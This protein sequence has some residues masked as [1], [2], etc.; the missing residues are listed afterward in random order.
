MQFFQARNQRLAVSSDVCIHLIETPFLLRSLGREKIPVS[1]FRS[2]AFSI[3]SNAINADPEH[4]P[5]DRFKVLHEVVLF[6]EKSANRHEN[7]GTGLVRRSRCFDIAC[8]NCK[9]EVDK[10]PVLLVVGDCDI[11]DRGV[12]MEDSSV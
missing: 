8:P 7:F 9:I 2:S 3:W 1:E 6:A 4:I 5:E 10:R 12:T 11:S